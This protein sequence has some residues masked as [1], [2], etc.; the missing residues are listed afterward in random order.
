M[1]GDKHVISLFADDVLLYLKYPDVSIHAVL[2]SI[3]TFGEL[4]GYKI[5]LSKSVAL[6]FNIPPDKPVQSPFQLSE[7]GF[8]YLGIFVPPDL[9][10]LFQTNY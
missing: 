10:N 3:A 1:D 7:K 8:K 2:N 9:S 5:N 4:S 6:P